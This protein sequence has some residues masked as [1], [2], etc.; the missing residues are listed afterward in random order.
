MKLNINKSKTNK[1]R[2][3]GKEKCKKKSKVS[4]IHI[5]WNKKELNLVEFILSGIRKLNLVVCR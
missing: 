4:G 2:C 5:Q 3:K 1:R